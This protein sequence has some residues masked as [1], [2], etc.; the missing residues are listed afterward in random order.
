ML[1]MADKDPPLILNIG[2][3]TEYFALQDPATKQLDNVLLSMQVSIECQRRRSRQ[4]IYPA[5][6]TRKFR[7]SLPQFIKKVIAQAIREGAVPRFPDRI[8]I[9]AHF[10]RADLPNFSDFWSQKQSFDGYGRTFTTPSLKLTDDD[11]DEMEKISSSTAI[12]APARKGEPAHVVPLRIYDTVLLA[13]GR[14]SLDSVAAMMGKA[15][16][17]L[18]S[19]YIKDRMDLFLR[20]CPEEFAAYALADADLALDAGL[21]FQ[22]LAKQLGLAKLPRTLAGFCA[23]MLANYA[24]EVEYDLDDALGVEV[25]KTRFYHEPS[26]RLRTKKEKVPKYDRQII[27]EIGAAG[28]HGGLNQTFYVGPSEIGEFCDIDLVSAYPTAMCGLKTPDYARHYHTTDIDEFGVDTVGVAHVEFQ[29]PPETRF[30]CLPVRADGNLFFP[31]RGLST[32][33]SPEVFLAR[34]MGADLKINFGTIVPPANDRLMFGGFFADL[35][36]RRKNAPSELL[37]KVF[38]EI[39]NSAYGKTAQGVRP[40]RAFNSRR[41]EM[42]EIPPSALTS[43][44]LAAPTTGFVRALMCEIV[45]SVPADRLVINVTT[46][47]IL[48]DAS[49]TEIPLSGP[50]AQRYMRIRR[51]VFDDETSMLVVKHRVAQVVSMKTRGLFT[52]QRLGDEPEILAKAG[53]RPPVPREQHNEFISELYRNREPGQV[54]ENDSLISF[55]D[56]WVDERDLVNAKRKFRLNLEFDFKRRPVNPCEMPFGDGTHLAF[57]TVPWGTV[58]DVIDARLK[59][60]EWRRAHHGVLKTLPDFQRWEAFSHLSSVPLPKGAGYRSDGSFG[61]LKRQFCRA[62]VRNEW[63]L[64]RDGMTHKDVVAWLADNGID[65]TVNDLKNAAR[66][67]STLANQT[68]AVTEDTI[69]LLRVIAQQFPGLRLTEMVRPD[70]L[71]RARDALNL[72]THDDDQEG[73]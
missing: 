12:I 60:E 53:I 5:G 63:G 73:K 11:D 57:K 26:G 3:D 55:R 58:E 70:D 48:T 64:S 69:P 6:R 17:E 27:E 34:S 24:R 72:T 61:H 42:D 2:F 49:L 41:G 50:L 14:A 46:D 38:K 44:W 8:N 18:P 37:A 52:A 40:K 71:A 56:Q 45:N 23:P 1:F 20:D 22:N 15:K 25:R 10:S 66:D 59:F 47:G 29:F 7:P 62:L 21:V 65:L 9:F 31:L 35:M 51:E 36:E 4:I 33:T 13:P 54:Y 19:G 68:I 16:V 67:A 39:M 43:A 30:P 28:Y 32:C